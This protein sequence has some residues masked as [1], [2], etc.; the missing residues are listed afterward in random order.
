[1]PD[2]E[3]GA[4]RLD[5]DLVYTGHIYPRMLD[6]FLMALKHLLQSGA[7]VP[8][9]WVYGEK[10]HHLRV[11]DELREYIV[12]KSRVSFVESLSVMRAA[13]GD[14]LLAPEAE[15]M[16]VERLLPL[17]FIVTPNAF[18]AAALS[19]IEVTTTADQEEAARRIA[20][21]GPRAVLVK[22]GRTAGPSSVDVLFYGRRITRLGAKRISGPRGTATH[23]AGCTLSAAIA[24]HL[25]LGA[26][27]EKAVSLAKRFVTR[28]IRR[29]V[30]IGHGIPPV[31]PT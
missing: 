8:T 19:G 13:G 14:R 5:C 20:K 2:D 28:A 21:L 10:P 12:F 4:S 29:S 16:M 23:G 15:R 24:A 17:A 1:P 25:A 7:P 6:P 11:D 31:G 18:E 9:V 26:R 3:S 30:L 27:L 22:G